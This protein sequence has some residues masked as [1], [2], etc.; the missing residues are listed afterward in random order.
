[1]KKKQIGFSLLFVLA[2]AGCKPA[3]TSSAVSSETPASSS[4]VVSSSTVPET[5]YTITKNVTG[6]GGDITFSAASA[7]KGTVI[8]VTAVPETGYALKTI[9]SMDV[10]LTATEEGKTYTFKMPDTDVTVNASFEKIVNKYSITKFQNF[11]SYSATLKLITVGEKIAEGANTTAAFL[12]ESYR[13]GLVGY[14]NDQKYDLVQDT[15]DT[16]LWEFS[17]AMPSEDIVL[18]LLAPQEEESTGPLY[19]L[20]V[21]S[22]VKLWGMESGKHY[23]ASATFYLANEAGYQP[24]VTAYLTDTPATAISFS[25][26]SSRGAYMMSAYDSDFNTITKPITIKVT[27]ENVGVKTITYAAT[28]KLSADTSSLPSS[29]TPGDVIRVVADP[30]DGYYFE[31]A[32]FSD[33]TL[34]E[35]TSSAFTFVMPSADVT[36]TFSIKEMGEVVMNSA[37][38]IL[39][40][41]LFDDYQMSHE[42]DGYIPGKTLYVKFTTD[43]EYRVTALTDGAGVN[44]FSTFIA[45]QFTGYLSADTTGTLTLT[46]TV[47]THY[48]V[49]FATVAHVTFSL[50][51]ESDANV[52]P[53]AVVY[54]DVTVESGY[55][56]TSVGSVGSNVE[57]TSAWGTTYQFTSIAANVTITATAEAL[58][59]ST[60]TFTSFSGC[61][62]QYVKNGDNNNIGSLSASGDTSFSCYVGDEIRFIVTVPSNHNTATLQVTAGSATAA[63]DYA[64]E[65]TAYANWEKTITITDATE[66][67]ALSLGSQT[68]RSGTITY[69]SDDASGTLSGTYTVNNGSTADL[70]TASGMNGL[71]AYDHVDISL[72]TPATGKNYA[73]T[74]SYGD[75]IVDNLY[76]GTDATAFSF[77]VPDSDFTLAIVCGENV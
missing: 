73:L 26:D 58:V 39:S 70:S 67:I 25:F 27:A 37:D 3:V 72:A 52:Y 14:V 35:Q 38:H 65:I 1:M 44:T 62:V 24:T 59:A 7:A 45:N 16:D 13:G 11:S 68:V 9:D 20:D 17:F 60:V 19:T 53:G 51:N 6:E 74:L 5:L 4:A 47:S 40:Y 30:I 55:K 63:T 8:T 15:S 28:D 32:T 77:D 29:A 34:T 41:H 54:F 61:T 56:L 10:T 36:V 22:H 75:G 31:K 50:L 71:V 43:D 12:I 57:V 33:A 46:P 66:S 18:T 76:A 64:A 42:I 23:S 49:S 2:L 48:S 69:T 21:D